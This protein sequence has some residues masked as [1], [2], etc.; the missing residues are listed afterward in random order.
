MN[1][2][3]DYDIQEIVK[4]LDENIQSITKNDK[5]LKRLFGVSRINKIRSSMEDLSNLLKVRYPDIVL[6]NYD[7]YGRVQNTN[8]LL[9]TGRLI[10]RGELSEE[11]RDMRMSEGITDA[12][13]FQ[14]EDLES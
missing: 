11:I 3:N 10:Q 12:F 4:N 1:L 14:E 7:L 9:T 13:A 2:I 5:A 6:I 8:L